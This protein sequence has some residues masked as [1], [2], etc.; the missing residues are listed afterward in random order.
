MCT[1]GASNLVSALS[2]SEIACPAI[3][4]ELLAMWAE[5]ITA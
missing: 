2:D 1:F 4:E 3:D 5:K